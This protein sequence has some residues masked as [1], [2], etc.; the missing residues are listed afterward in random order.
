MSS[1]TADFISRHR[2]ALTALWYAIALL[3]V[4]RF[5]LRQSFE[6]PAFVYQNF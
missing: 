4:L 6:V 1:I 2:V 5:V 3:L